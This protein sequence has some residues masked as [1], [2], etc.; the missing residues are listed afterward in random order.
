M[1]NGLIM[2]N[3][4][5][6]A[7]TYEHAKMQRGKLASVQA[8]TRSQLYT[9]DTKPGRNQSHRA[10]TREQI[11]WEYGLALPQYQEALDTGRGFAS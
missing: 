1:S 6:L 9:R 10:S 3:P 7:V 4:L 2:M 11:S 8:L 5:E